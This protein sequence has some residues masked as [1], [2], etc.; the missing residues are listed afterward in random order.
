[1]EYSSSSSGIE[2]GWLREQYVSHVLR[3]FK[4]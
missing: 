1:M 4:A 2:F 3:G